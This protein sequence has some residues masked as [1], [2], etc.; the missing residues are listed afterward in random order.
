MTRCGLLKTAALIAF[1]SAVACPLEASAPAAE[2]DLVRI[3]DQVSTKKENPDQANPLVKHNP[4][5]IADAFNRMPIDAAKAQAETLIWTFAKAL[6]LV[7]A[8][9]SLFWWSGYY[10]TKKIFL[11]SA[12]KIMHSH[13]KKDPVEPPT[14][15]AA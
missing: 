14:K 10:L 12:V 7:G 11:R 6:I 13:K 9:W 3:A 5:T 8:A 15:A 2:S 4:L 1:A